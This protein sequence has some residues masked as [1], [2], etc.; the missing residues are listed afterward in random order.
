MIAEQSYSPDPQA[1]P[2]FEVDLMFL[3]LAKLIAK[4]TAGM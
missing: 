3:L 2:F 1:L 4:P